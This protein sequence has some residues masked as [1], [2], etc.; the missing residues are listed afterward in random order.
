MVEPIKKVSSIDSDFERL[1]QQSLANKAAAAASAPEEEKKEAAAPE[2]NMVDD[3]DDKIAAFK[4]KF[5][6]VNATFLEKLGKSMGVKPTK[7][8]KN[9]IKERKGNI[10]V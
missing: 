8:V 7:E 6:A 1:Y 4:K 9:L 10:N 2:K 3:L 5:D